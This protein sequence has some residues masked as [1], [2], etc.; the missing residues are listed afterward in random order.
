MSYI[1]NLTESDS[2]GT[3]TMRLLDSTSGWGWFT[4]GLGGKLFTW[5]LTSSWL[6]SC[7]LGTSHDYWFKVQCI[8][9]IYQKRWSV[10]RWSW[11][12]GGSGNV[13][14]TT[15]IAKSLE[16]RIRHLVGIGTKLRSVCT[17][18]DSTVGLK[19][20]RNS[21][22]LIQVRTDGTMARQKQRARTTPRWIEHS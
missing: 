5:S 2:S 9:R 21:L 15:R 8:K 22:L 11:W 16:T 14:Q 3:V 6:T 1:P 7:L 20:E 18:Y 12:E 10:L 17:S 13:W 4:S 19:S